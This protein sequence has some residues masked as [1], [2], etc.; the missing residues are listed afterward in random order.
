VGTFGAVDR[1]RRLIAP[2]ATGGG[3]AAR[4]RAKALLD[5][6]RGFAGKTVDEVAPHSVG[7]SG[8]AP[9]VSNKGGVGQRLEAALG[10]APRFDDVDDPASGV[11]VKTVPF[12]V[13]VTGRARVLEATFITTASAA[14]L[15]HETWATSRARKKLARVLFVPVE[16]STL[17][18][19]TAFLYEPDAVT[20]E[21]LRTDWEDLADLVARGL[22]FACSSR[23][24]VLLHLR[25][26]AK[27]SFVTTRVDLVDEADALVRPQGFYL[28]RAFTEALLDA[29]FPAG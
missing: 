26:K 19:G 1:S 21:V 20:M 17:R 9:G 29:L 15:V 14:D 12:R 10:L 22:G 6:A 2:T 3:D 18:V 5:R 25:P 11:E 28:R 7:R 13:D 16:R 27:D 8:G 24:G 23:R 4:E